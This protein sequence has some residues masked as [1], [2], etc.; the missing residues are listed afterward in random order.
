VSFASGV[1]FLAGADGTR[2][3]AEELP[4]AIRLSARR[5]AGDVSVEF[6]LELDRRTYTPK[7]QSIRYEN[8][9]RTLEL[10]LYSEPVTDTVAEVSFEPPAAAATPAP[11][12]ASIPTVNPLLVELEVHHALHRLRACLGETIE[13]HQ[14]PRGLAV[15]GAVASP[16]RREQVVAALAPLGVSVEI[17]TASEL[18]REIPPESVTAEAPPGAKRKPAARL[19]GMNES[20][21]EEFADRA[22]SAGEDLMRDAQALRHLAERLGG[23]AGL[24]QRQARWLVEMMS[25][26]H[27]RDLEAKAEA[28]RVLLRASPS[29]AAPPP[30]ADWGTEMMRIFGLSRKLNQS[31]R[32]A[33]AGEESVAG[34][35]GALAP[36]QSALKAACE[37]SL[38]A[39]RATQPF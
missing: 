23:R 4:S 36:L 24:D 37:R 7:L 5:T 16:E 30:A 20:E 35:A 26:D 9:A 1:A 18:L 17:R 11:A 10:Q 14:T 2:L 15:R 13:V 12:A 29:A 19:F 28:L 39:H 38:A 21:A 3:K 32:A 6:V 31:L 34:A 27:L 25:Y 22:L 33:L 8:A